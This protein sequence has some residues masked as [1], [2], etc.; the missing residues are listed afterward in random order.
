MTVKKTLQDLYYGR[1]DGLEPPVKQIPGYLKARQK[2]TKSA[3]KLERELNKEQ[4]KLF[5]EYSDSRTGLEVCMGQADF[6]H[7]FRTGARLMAEV[8]SEAPEKDT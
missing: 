5:I 3:D 6:I 1:I 7:G 8:F 2:V 4:K